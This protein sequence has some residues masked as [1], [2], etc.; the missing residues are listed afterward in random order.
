[1]CFCIF[2]ILRRAMAYLCFY[3]AM[4]VFEYIEYFLLASLL[5]LENCTTEFLIVH[6]V[7]FS[8]WN[9]SY[10]FSNCVLIAMDSMFVSY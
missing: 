3:L 7:L 5:I 1:M 9:V 4:Y 6:G 2:Y 10:M 8:S